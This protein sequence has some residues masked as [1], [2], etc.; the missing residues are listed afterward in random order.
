M[1]FGS[2]THP[3]VDFELLHDDRLLRGHGL[4]ARGA[5]REATAERLA[6]GRGRRA[7]ERLHITRDDASGR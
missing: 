2:N 7:G 3:A 6:H 5:R 4:T 1:C